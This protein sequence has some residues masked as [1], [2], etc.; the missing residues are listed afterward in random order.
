[1]R[2]YM[3]F[4]IMIL[5]SVVIMFYLFDLDNVVFRIASNLKNMSPSSFRKTQ[6]LGVIIY[7]LLGISFSAVGYYVAKRKNRNAW[8][9]AI[10]CFL[11]NLWAYL[12]IL[13]LPSKKLGT[14][15]KI[16]KIN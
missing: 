3:Y 4:I 8:G 1:M 16:K 5:I 12:L 14:K 13:C 7:I 2:K 10:V 9:W 6:V 15:T 11:W